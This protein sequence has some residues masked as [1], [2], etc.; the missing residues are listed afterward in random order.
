[1]A[2]NSLIF[3]FKVTNINYI[4]DHKSNNS[5]LPSSNSMTSISSTTFQPTTWFSSSK[6]TFEIET[7]NGNLYPKLPETLNLIKSIGDFYPKLNETSNLIKSFG[8]IYSKLPESSTVTK[9]IGDLYSKLPGSTVAKPVNNVFSS[10]YNYLSS[11][12]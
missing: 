1:M 8:S 10:T 7:N 4:N 9:S 5:E 6:S 12:F 3:K 2:K 11:F